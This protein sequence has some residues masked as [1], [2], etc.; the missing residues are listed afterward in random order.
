MVI[1]RFP[2]RMHTKL[3]VMRK[4]HASEWNINPDCIGIMGFSAG[5]HLAST[6]AS[7]LPKNFVLLF[8]FFFI[9]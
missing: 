7:M 8:R 9:R 6:V 3:F 4:E 5:G 2:C 1:G